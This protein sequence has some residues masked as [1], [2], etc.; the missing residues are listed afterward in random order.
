MASKGLC[1]L[2]LL[3]SVV[4]VVACETPEH[5]RNADAADQLCGPMC[6][7]V[8]QCNSKLDKT[9]CMTACEAKTSPR[10]AYYSDAYIADQ[11]ACSDK[12][13]CGPDVAASIAACRKLAR[14]RF[15]PS[16]AAKDFCSKVHERD[17]SCGLGAVDTAHCLFHAKNFSDETLGRLTGCLDDPC[18]H[19]GKCIAAVVG[20]DNGDV[21]DEEREELY[22][23]GEIPTTPALVSLSGKTIVFG[24]HSTPVVG[25]K[26]CV[27]ADASVPCVTSGTDGTFSIALP[28]TK[29]V[30]LEIVGPQPDF[31]PI[32]VGYPAHA[33]DTSGI[34]IGVPRAAL[35]SKRYATAGATFPDA[36]TG[37]ILATAIATKVGT[38]DPHAVTMRLDPKGAAAHDIE[39]TKPEFAAKYHVALF[40][41]VAPGTQH[42]VFEGLSCVPAFGALPTT[43]PNTVRVIVAPGFETEVY[44]RCGD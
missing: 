6:A 31:S 12:Q 11:R 10:V 9:K 22:R 17:V 25:A 3:V 13:A 4:A 43:Q 15:E 34:V 18:G 32:L 1:G 20:P 42:V 38:V 39:S 8:S 36:T 27:H 5:P 40:T 7:R 16:A 2:A 41:G 29:D 37:S 33:N 44:E 14:A 28:A 30:A 19:Y 23:H 35:L 24:D 21:S 26:I